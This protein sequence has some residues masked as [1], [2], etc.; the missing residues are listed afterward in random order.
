[1]F[2]FLE[3]CTCE[4]HGRYKGPDVCGSLLTN[5]FLWRDGMSLNVTIY[6][7]REVTKE[8][9]DLFPVEHNSDCPSAEHSNLRAHLP[10]GRIESQRLQANPRKARKG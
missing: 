5:S 3:I 10:R 2:K 9:C 6:G 8:I 7:G 1:M 4:L